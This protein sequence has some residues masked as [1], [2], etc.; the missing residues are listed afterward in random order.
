MSSV[1][2][3]RQRCPAAPGRAIGQAILKMIEDLAYR[4]STVERAKGVLVPDE[5]SRDNP[6]L[7]DLLGSNKTA[8]KRSVLRRTGHSRDPS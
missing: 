5:P 2:T 4:P 3:G 8:A 1:H 7:L 6:F